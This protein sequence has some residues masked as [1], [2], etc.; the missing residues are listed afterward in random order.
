VLRNREW[1]GVEW[2][3]VEGSKVKQLATG[4]TTPSLIQ[5]KPHISSAIGRKEIKRNQNKNNSQPKFE[6]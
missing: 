2:S 4:G 3:G 5:L 6:I 1:D